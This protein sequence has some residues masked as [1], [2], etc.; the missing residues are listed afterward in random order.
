MGSER[1]PTLNPQ[2]Q[3]Y[4]DKWMLPEKYGMDSVKVTDQYFLAAG[5]RD[6]DFAV[7]DR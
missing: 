3:Q 5:T 2:K 6:D 7:V 4:V 1:K